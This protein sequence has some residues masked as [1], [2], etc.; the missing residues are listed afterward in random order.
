MTVSLVLSGC[1]K[2]EEFAE[3]PE[4]EFNELDVAKT[5]GKISEDSTYLY[6]LAEQGDL[7]SAWFWRK[8]PTFFNLT[9]ALA[10]TRLL[11]TVI[12][13]DL[14]IFAPTDE[15]FRNL[16]KELGVNSITQ[17]SAEQ[18]KPILLY[19][20]VKG[21]VKSYKLSRDIEHAVVYD[22]CNQT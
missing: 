2:N 14:T 3:A 20:V 16:F 11:S 4:V 22:R 13:N 6:K 18:L 5:L 7:K 15:A 1:E 17:L 19:H 9:Y 10:K 8:A 12:S 21:K